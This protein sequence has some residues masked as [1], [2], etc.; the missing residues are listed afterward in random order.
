MLI[1]IDL[2]LQKDNLNQRSRYQIDKVIIWIDIWN[3]VN[4]YSQ[5]L[6]AAMKRYSAK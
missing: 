5:N 1:G 4:N 3:H 2:N 6:E